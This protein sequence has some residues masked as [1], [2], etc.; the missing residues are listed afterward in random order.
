[1]TG[2]R[3][4]SFFK[5]KLSPLTPDQKILSDVGAHLW[6]IFDDSAKVIVFKGQL[7]DHHDQFQITFERN[8]GTTFWTEHSRSDEPIENIFNLL[9]QLKNTKRFE[10]NGFTHIQLRLNEEKKLSADFVYIAEG[11]SWPGLYMRGV[12]D[13]S[14]AE[15]EKY[16]LPEDV[17]EARSK[18]FSD[19]NK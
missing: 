2:N 6:S 13:L 16:Y 9:K 5:R 11:N 10:K 1:M 12:S 7:F 19:T 15:I 18:K 17:W 4:G 14:R 3:W 8:D